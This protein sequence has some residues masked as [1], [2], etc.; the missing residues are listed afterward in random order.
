MLYRRFRVKT[1]DP[2]MLEKAE[3]IIEE[4]N[5]S[6]E[7]LLLLFGAIEPNDSFKSPEVRAMNAEQP[8]LECGMR[9][10]PHDREEPRA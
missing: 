2:R 3:R 8:T 5:L 4:K 7:D 1:D 9:V 10:T 6:R